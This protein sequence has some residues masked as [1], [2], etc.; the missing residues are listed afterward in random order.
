M[1]SCFLLLLIKMVGTTPGV[2]GWSLVLTV[3][4]LVMLGP[5]A[6]V[7]AL[8]TASMRQLGGMSYSCTRSV[9][10]GASACS[11]TRLGGMLRRR[12]AC[13]F[14]AFT[15]SFS[16]CSSALCRQLGRVPGPS[17]RTLRAVGHC[18][19]VPPGDVRAAAPC[20]HLPRLG[21]VVSPAA[22]RAA[23]GVP[24]VLL[25]RATLEAPPYGCT[26]TDATVGG[27]AYRHRCA[28]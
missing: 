24:P 4:L 23:S 28:C 8:I 1:R 19:D 16:R 18:A 14:L 13:L 21:G 10:A 20:G 27:V 3:I 22:V 15:Y 2:S 6:A 7:L 11:L 12:G 17:A 26:R 25:S 9:C 5:P